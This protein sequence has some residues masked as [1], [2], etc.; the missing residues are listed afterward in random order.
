VATLSGLMPI[1]DVQVGDLVWSRN[2][3]TGETQLREVVQVFETADQA[4]YE[5]DVETASGEVETL[6]T[7]AEHPF[8]VADLGWVP[9]SR[10]LAG[11][12]LISN[13][14][15]MLK[16]RQVRGSPRRETVY[17]FEVAG[18]HTYFVGELGVWVHNLCA[19]GRARLAE[20]RKRRAARD[21]ARARGE[22]VPSANP[23]FADY[24]KADR[25]IQRAAQEAPGRNTKVTSEQPRDALGR[26]ISK[27]ASDQGIPG[28][29][30]VDDFVELA[31]KD[32]FELLGREVP[33]PTPFGLRYI[34]VVLRNPRTQAVGGIEL[35]SSL[36]AFKRFDGPAR[37]QFAGDWW[38]NRF[39]GEAIGRFEGLQ[40]DYTIKILWE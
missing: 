20:F 9:A 37:Q 13:T 8:W 11:D 26:F 32:G 33:V 27:S 38:I 15:A 21:R 7:T 17:N 34:D 36:S 31:Q 3:T 4:I 39:G 28:S 18:D 6:G 22:E 14:G 2:E 1:E 35:K 12:E 23:G 5:V 24:A 30:S 25:K 29:S 10:L 16:V 40:I 19:A